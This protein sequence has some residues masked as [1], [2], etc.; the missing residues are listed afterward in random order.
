MLL[1]ISE[2]E[3]ESLKSHTQ[4]SNLCSR[5]GTFSPRGHL[6]CARGITDAQR[7]FFSSCS[8]SAQKQKK[9]RFMY[10]INEDIEQQSCTILLDDVNLSWSISTLGLQ[11]PVNLCL[12]PDRSFFSWLMSSCHPPMDRVDR[13]RSTLA[14]GRRRFDA[15]V[16]AES[17]RR[18]EDWTCRLR[19]RS[20][21]TMNCS[22]HCAHRRMSLEDDRL[23]SSKERNESDRLASL[24][25]FAGDEEE[26]SPHPIWDQCRIDLHRGCCI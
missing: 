13:A 8:I 17:R 3:D 19:S 2:W 16:V 26:I 18:T 9:T 20:M 12:H 14:A 7:P 23:R 5:R 22:S 4:T 21:K 24:Y 1:T 15:T 25:L 11:R 6:E 10:N